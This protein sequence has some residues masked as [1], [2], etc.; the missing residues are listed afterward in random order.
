MYLRSILFAASLMRVICAVHN[1]DDIVMLLVLLSLPVG[2]SML[3]E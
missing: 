1:D 2:S 3:S